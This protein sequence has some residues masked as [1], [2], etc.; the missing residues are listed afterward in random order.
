VLMHVYA[1][2]VFMQVFV[3]TCVHFQTMEL[4][5]EDKSVENSF[6][7]F[8]CCSKN[9]MSGWSFNTIGSVHCCSEDYYNYKLSNLNSSPDCS[10]CMLFNP[11]VQSLDRQEL[12]F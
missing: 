2:Y 4:F 11:W 10:I 1:C 3:F 9:L 6:L 12:R 8:S 5:W 7:N